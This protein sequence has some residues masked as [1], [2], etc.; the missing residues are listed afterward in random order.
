MHSI[1]KYS[2]NNVIDVNLRQL[3]CASLLTFFNAKS[4]DG[5]W[6]SLT[7]FDDFWCFWRFLTF[8][9]VFWRFKK[10]EKEWKNIL[11]KIDNNF[12]YFILFYKQG[13]SV[14]LAEL[15]KIVYL[16]KKKKKRKWKLSKNLNYHISKKINLMVIFNRQNKRKKILHYLLNYIYLTW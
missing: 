9:D 11:K 13:L 8:F 10:F 1:G 4:N 5:Y 16:H 6:S 14:H 2:I 7:I 15:S 3:N 12:Y